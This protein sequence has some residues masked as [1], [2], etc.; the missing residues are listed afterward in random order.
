MEPFAL[1]ISD[2]AKVLSLG[3]T[4]VYRLIADGRLQTLKIGRRTLVLVASIHR[5]VNQQG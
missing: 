1:T 5:L 4:S 2:T 3:R